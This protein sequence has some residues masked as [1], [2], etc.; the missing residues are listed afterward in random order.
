MQI[1]FNQFE[2]YISDTI[3][4]R[5]LSYFKNG[6]VQ[7]PAE[8]RPGEYEAIVEGSVDYT[9]RLTIKKG[10]ITGFVCDCPYDMG[11]VCKHVA[12]VI[13]YL[14]QD[15]LDLKTKKKSNFLNISIYQ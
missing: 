6:R 11:P 1:P 4:K 2:Q 13:L 5:G 10:I 15:E 9:V 8:I 3:L 7:E 12:A 14:Q